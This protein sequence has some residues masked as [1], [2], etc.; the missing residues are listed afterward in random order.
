VA[1]WVPGGGAVS[2]RELVE[3]EEGVRIRSASGPHYL[4]GDTRRAIKEEVADAPS[5]GEDESF[6][7]PK[8]AP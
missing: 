5:P 2:S 1:T 3:E 7:F 4:D 8:P 6:S